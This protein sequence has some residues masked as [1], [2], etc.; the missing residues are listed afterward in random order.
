MTNKFILPITSSTQSEI[1]LNNAEQELTNKTLVAPV[2]KNSTGTVMHYAELDGDENFHINGVFTGQNVMEDNETRLASAEND[3]DE[4]QGA[5]ST[6][7][8]TVANYSNTLEPYITLISDVSKSWNTDQYGQRLPNSTWYSICFDGE[9]FVAINYNYLNDTAP[10]YATSTN[11]DY[12]SRYDF[13]HLTDN[14]WQTICYGNGKYV[15]LSSYT[16]DEGVY[17]RP[18]YAYTSNISGRWTTD[19]GLALSYGEWKAIC[20][21]NNKFVAVG[22][23]KCGVSDDGVSWISGTLTGQYRSV[24]F[25]NNKFVAIG[26]NKSSST[27]NGRTWNSQDITGSFYSICYGNGKYVAVGTDKFAYSTDGTTFEYIDISGSWRSVCYGDNVF[28]AVNSNRNSGPSYAYSYDG[29]NW[30]QDTNAVRLP[31]DLWQCICYGNHRFIVVSGNSST[32]SYSYAY[33]TSLQINS[34]INITSD[35]IRALE[36]KVNRLCAALGIQ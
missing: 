27:N 32:L 35:N 10:T 6:L 8:T 9:R 11:G 12:W 18:S 2:I 3:V 26:D 33:L 7:Q 5:V 31:R 13:Q 1:T 16:G 30:V 4:L 20:F 19:P 28:V 36:E 25:G 34:S 21:G 29:V 14:E 17:D 15:A 22:T 23:N 24:C